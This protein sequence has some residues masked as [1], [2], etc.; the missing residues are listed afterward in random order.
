MGKEWLQ[1]VYSIIVGLHEMSGGKY[2][3][4][5]ILTKETKYCMA[6]DLPFGPQENGR[7]AFE[8]VM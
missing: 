6:N 8:Y 5:I 1:E 3:P 2:S 7:K 4:L